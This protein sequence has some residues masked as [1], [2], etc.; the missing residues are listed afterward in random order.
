ME[1]KLRMGRPR[2]LPISERPMRYAVY[3]TRDAIEA[4]DEIAQEQNISRSELIRKII[5]E[6]LDSRGEK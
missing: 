6:Y 2:T 4:L 1:V 5:K 3:T